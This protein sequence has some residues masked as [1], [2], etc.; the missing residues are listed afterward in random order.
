MPL[1][2]RNECLPQ[3]PHDRIHT[4][5]HFR[6]PLHR[7]Q[8]VIARKLD[9]FNHAVRRRRNLGK[10]FSDLLH[11]LVVEGIHAVGGDTENLREARACLYR[12]AVGRNTRT[13]SLRVL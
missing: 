5:K 3:F 12:H 10:G 2:R 1:S 13:V 8:E 6:M 9:C 7:N 11:R 4:L